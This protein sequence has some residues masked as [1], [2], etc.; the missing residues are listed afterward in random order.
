[1]SKDWTADERIATARGI[2]HRILMQP[3]GTAVRVDIAVAFLVL[4]EPAAELNHNQREIDN[5]LYGQEETM[6][7][8]R[9]QETP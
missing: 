8:Y 3:P 6:R 5:A 4:N 7:R 9:G 1:M 2:L